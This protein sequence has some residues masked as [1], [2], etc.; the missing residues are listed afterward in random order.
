MRIEPESG[1]SRPMMVLIRTDLPLPEP[2]D[3]HQRF[4][5]GDVEVDPVQHHL[6]AE[7]LVQATDRDLWRRFGHAEK[8]SS[9]M[10]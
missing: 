9:V 5:A 4:A 2:P 1:C 8:N 7:A 10:M 6:L 3:H